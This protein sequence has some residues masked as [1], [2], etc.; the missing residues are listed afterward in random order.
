V[1]DDLQPTVASLG[2][3]SPDLENL[4]KNV[5]PL[6]DAGDKGLPALSRTLSVVFFLLST[7]FVWRSFYGMR[8]GGSQP[9]VSHRAVGAVARGK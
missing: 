5:D 6:I 3:L 8:I 4:F 2:D 7:V 1:L 9:S